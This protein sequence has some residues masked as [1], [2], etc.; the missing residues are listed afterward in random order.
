MRRCYCYPCVTVGETEEQERLR[1]L[2]ERV[3]LV[4]GSVEFDLDFE[5]M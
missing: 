1:N 4:K 2:L 5:C 3:L